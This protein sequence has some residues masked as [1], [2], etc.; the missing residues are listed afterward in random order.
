MMYSGD[1]VYDDFTTSG[2]DHEWETNY[3]ARE[4]LI[5]GMVE[6]A[7]EPDYGDPRGDA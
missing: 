5:C 2:C 1:E 7:P 4:C 6:D 3:P